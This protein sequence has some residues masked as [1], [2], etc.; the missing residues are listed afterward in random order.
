MPVEFPTDGVGS[1]SKVQIPPGLLSKHTG[2]HLL[3]DLAH[4]V[5]PLKL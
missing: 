5:N 2:W 3:R 1:N 4:A